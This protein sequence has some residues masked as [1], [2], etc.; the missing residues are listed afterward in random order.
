MI[1]YPDR[2]SDPAYMYDL[3]EIQDKAKDT[4]AV[5]RSLDIPPEKVILIGDSGGDGPSVHSR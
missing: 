4:E 2:E 1:R 5:I 3:L